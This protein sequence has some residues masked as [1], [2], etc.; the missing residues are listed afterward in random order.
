[1]LRVALEASS[2]SPVEPAVPVPM[3]EL[4]KYWEKTE[5]M[6]AINDRNFRNDNIENKNGELFQRI[7]ILS[8]EGNKTAGIG[9][10]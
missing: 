1:M 5:R 10:Q 2:P 4:I 9:E 7:S 8:F 6:T 3:N